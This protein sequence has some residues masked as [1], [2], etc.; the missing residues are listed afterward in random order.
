MSYD[1]NTLLGVYDGLPQQDPFLLDLL[2]KNVALFDT[3][4]IDFDQLTTELVLAPF[5]SPFVAGKTNT[6]AGTKLKKFKPA[7]VKPKDAIDPARVLTRM[8]GEPIGGKM[9]AGERR[10]AIVASIILDQKQRILRTQEWMLAQ[11]LKTGKVIVAGEDYPSVEVDF[12]RAAGNT[13]VL[14]GGA[15]WDQT[16][17]RTPNKD[18]ESWLALMIAPCTHIIFGKGAW[19]NY[20]SDTTTKDVRDTTLGSQTQLKTEPSVLLAAYRGK[21]DGGPELWTYNGFYHDGAGA[22]QQYVADNQVLLV[23]TAGKGVRAY[24]AVLDA[25]ADYVATE[26]W[27]KNWSEKDPG[28]EWVMT[29]SAP[30]PVIPMIDSTV[31]A[32][33]Y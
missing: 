31:C 18:L 33:V 30:L 28:V 1:T 24:G 27:P 2:C 25:E 29:Q 15:R 3:S 13:I 6:M 22:R 10:Q 26:A 5:V 20:I 12:G 9:S 17:T 11:I 4:E 19:A 8:P 23:S 7:Y 32:T 16:A 21:Y 14:A